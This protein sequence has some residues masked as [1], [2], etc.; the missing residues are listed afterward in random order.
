MPNVDLFVRCPRKHHVWLKQMMRSVCKFASGFRNIHLIIPAGDIDPVEQLWIES[1]GE[2]FERHEYHPDLVVHQNVEWKDKEFLFSMLQV[3]NADVICGDA[4]Y[5]VFLDSDCL[6]VEPITP[7]DFIIGGKPMIIRRP[8]VEMS[9]AERKWQ[10]CITAATGLPAPYECMVRH[11]E[12]H[13]PRTCEIARGMIKAHTGMEPV[14]YYFK[15]R[16]AYPQDRVEFPLLGAVALACH[17]EKYNIIDFKTPTEPPRK[18]LQGWS[19]HRD[20]ID[21]LF[22]FKDQIPRFGGMRTFR[23]VVEEVLG[24]V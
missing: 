12:V 5:I 20:G 9:D 17:P 19:H 23:S 22:D 2:F 1:V 15:G 4:D 18:L 8:Y 7:A 14:D 10:S 16:N 11:P 13:I 21:G 6:I 3:L 24:S